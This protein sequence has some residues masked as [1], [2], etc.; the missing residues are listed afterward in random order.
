VSKPRR[1]APELA[2]LRRAWARIIEG[3]GAWPCGRC[4]HPVT[5]E[6]RW[7][8]GHKVAYR[9]GG[10]TSMDNTAP[11]HGRCNESEGGKAGAAITNSRRRPARHTPGSIT[12]RNTL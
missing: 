8:V 11:E 10:P 1:D 5:V 4:G 12:E 7:H 2:K 6:Q 3:Q 9:D